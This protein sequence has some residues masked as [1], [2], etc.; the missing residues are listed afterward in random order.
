MACQDERGDVVQT[1][2]LGPQMEI[3]VGHDLCE[4]C[5]E[6][7]G[8]TLGGRARWGHRWRFMWA[9]SVAVGAPC[10]ARAA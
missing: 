8:V 2:P 6:T 5:P 1:R 10:G 3:P 7:I 9:R 4:R